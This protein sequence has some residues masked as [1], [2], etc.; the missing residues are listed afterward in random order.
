M[1]KEITAQE[2]IRIYKRLNCKP[3]RETDDTIVCD[4]HPNG[5]GQLKVENMRGY[6]RYYASSVVDSNE[7]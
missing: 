7:G 2:Y 4:V 3:I 6:P 5:V 1:W